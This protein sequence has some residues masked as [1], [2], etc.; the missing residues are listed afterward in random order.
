MA[1]VSASVELILDTI[2]CPAEKK[3]GVVMASNRVRGGASYS[4]AE[5]SPCLVVTSELRPKGTDRAVLQTRAPS[6]FDLGRAGASGLISELITGRWLFKCPLCLP[7]LFK[8][9]NTWG[10]ILIF[11]CL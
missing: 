5:E 4:V 9:N 2:K 11:P 10:Y 7:T 3:E 8:A 1:K 6:G